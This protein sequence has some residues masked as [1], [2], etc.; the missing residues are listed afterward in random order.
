MQFAE[1]VSGNGMADVC[2][3]L[4]SVSAPVVLHPQ[5]HTLKMF[6]EEEMHLLNHYY[7]LLYHYWDSGCMNQY[8]VILL[9]IIKTH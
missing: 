2:F 9:L 1:C 3:N 4:D 8:I 7:D 6:K 5:Q